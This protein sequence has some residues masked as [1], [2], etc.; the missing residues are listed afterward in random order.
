M[1]GRSTQEEGRYQITRS[2]YSTQ[3]YGKH[4]GGKSSSAHR[5]TSHLIKMLPYRNG[6]LYPHAYRHE[7]FICY[8]TFYPSHRPPHVAGFS[9]IPGPLR[10]GSCLF[11][12][13]A[14]LLIPWPANPTVEYMTQTATRSERFQS[15]VRVRTKNIHTTVG[16][17]TTRSRRKKR[18]SH[19]QANHERAC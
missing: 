1:Q 9:T 15:S 16:F 3:Y 17:R 5:V 2:Y 6:A 18:L 11:H 19:Q 7:R 4:P 14:R 10:N 8:Q 13:S 12:I